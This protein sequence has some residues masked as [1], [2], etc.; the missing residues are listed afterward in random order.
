MAPLNTYCLL[1]LHDNKWLE[2]LILD[3]DPLLKPTPNLKLFSSLKELKV[4]SAKLEKNG[5]SV[6]PI[7]WGP[8]VPAYLPAFPLQSAH[9]Q[10]FNFLQHERLPNSFSTLA[11]PR[12]FFQ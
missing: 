4:A 5:A 2:E 6:H 11:E 7:E 10:P 12:C 8:Y 9:A 1:K 3:H